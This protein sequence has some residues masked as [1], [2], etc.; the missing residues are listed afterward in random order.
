M[1]FVHYQIEMAA[2][3]MPEGRLEAYQMHF[4]TDSPQELSQT[5]EQ[6]FWVEFAQIRTCYLQRESDQRLFHL[7][8]LQELYQTPYLERGRHRTAMEQLPEHRTTQKL[9]EVS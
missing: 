4:E 6:C 3:L 9:V 1:H 7:R 8:S 5:M 2:R